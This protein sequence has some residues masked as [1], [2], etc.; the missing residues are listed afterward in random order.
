MWEGGVRIYGTPR[1]PNNYIVV[2]ENWIKL[3]SQ[4][5]W[6]ALNVRNWVLIPIW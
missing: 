6:E 1:V 3:G 5:Q 2:M 4:K